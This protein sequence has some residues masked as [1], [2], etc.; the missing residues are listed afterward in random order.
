MN[1]RNDM[2]RGMTII[3]IL[4]S[5]GVLLLVLTLATALFKQAFTHVTLTTE[6]MTN[7]QLA[8]LAMSKINNSLSQASVDVSF[9]D[10]GDGTPSPPVINQTA[11]S[12]AFYRVYTLVP[13]SIGID[14]DTQAPDPAY[15]VHVISYDNVGQTISECT[16]TW[17]VYNAGG[18]PAANTVVLATNVTNLA[19]A[20]VGTGASG[21]EYQFQLQMN[22]ILNPTKPESPYT[23][24]D[25]VDVLLRT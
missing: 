15:R 14:G 8:R 2:S 12:I 7:E 5:F 19:I 17:A 9:A 21:A 16:T 10:V 18:C 3:E 20:K 22:N 1:S 23:L 11:T 13:G 24:V 4:I 25:N 6:S